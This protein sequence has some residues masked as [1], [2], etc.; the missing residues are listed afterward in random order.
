MMHQHSHIKIM[1]IIR[2]T[3]IGEYSFHRIYQH[4]MLVYG[5]ANQ[6]KAL[7]LLVIVWKIEVK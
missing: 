2:I 4:M 3:S 1:E 7:R 6:F 5:K